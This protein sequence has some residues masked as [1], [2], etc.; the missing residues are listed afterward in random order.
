[1]KMI[2][3]PMKNLLTLIG[4]ILFIGCSN[5]SHLSIAT[6]KVYNSNFKYESVGRISAKSLVPIIWFY[7]LLN[8]G[9]KKISIEYIIDIALNES[10][11]DY[12]TNV[13]IFE[14][15]SMFIIFGWKSI[16]IIGEGWKR[17]KENKLEIKPESKIKTSKQVYDPNTGKLIKD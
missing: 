6:T 7:T 16:K 1:M 3:L 14:Q 8:P 15:E 17:V 5:I 10:G 11:A 2:K 4:I 12:I 9:Y 13:K